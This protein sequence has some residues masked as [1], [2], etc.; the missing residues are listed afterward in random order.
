MDKKMQA[1]TH[2]IVASHSQIFAF[3]L[4]RHHT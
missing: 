2:P 3:F 1:I 4:C